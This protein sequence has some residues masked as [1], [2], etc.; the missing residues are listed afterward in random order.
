MS[1]PHAFM[2]LAHLDWHRCCP[3]G[4][5]VEAANRELTASAEAAAA[6]ARE[7]RRCCTSEIER[8]ILLLL[9]SAAARASADSGYIRQQRACGVT[10]GAPSP[11][12]PSSAAGASVTHACHCVLVQVGGLVEKHRALEAAHRELQVGL[13]LCSQP[14]GNDMSGLETETRLGDRVLCSS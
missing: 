8:A 7:V 6:D 1:L 5:E 2:L 13:E 3:C 4:A 11:P 9:C 14:S 12:T 10:P